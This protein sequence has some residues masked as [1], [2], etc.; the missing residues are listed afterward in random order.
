MIRKIEKI[1]FM[2]FRFLRDFKKPLV[3]DI[4]KKAR[5]H[6]PKLEEYYLL[7]EEKDMQTQKGGRKSFEFDENGIPVVPSYIDVEEKGFHYY[8][9]TIGQYGLSVYHTYLASGNEEDKRRF[10]NI[11][12]WFIEHKSEDE[13]GVFWLT[14]TKKPEY[15]I[16]G[17]W[18]SAFS[19]SRALSI[20]LRAYQLTE[21]K[22]YLECAQKAL[23]IYSVLNTNG[24]VQA[25]ESSCTAFEE[26]TAPFNIL[27]FDG[28][29]FSMLGLFDFQRVFPNNKDVEKLVD[30]GINGLIGLLPNYDMNFWIKYSLVSQSFYPKNEPATRGYYYLVLT[31]LRVFYLYTD[32]EEFFNYYTKIKKYD[33]W[34]NICRMYYAKF[35][36]LKKLNRL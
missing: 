4:Q 21:D 13:R 8:P 10:L 30:Q 9:I 12:N 29:F 20:L 18:V 33:T 28:C 19:Q 3:Y 17:P 24:G 11:A 5:M 34:F 27:V 36:A 23:K 22:S 2:F 16:E 26:Y 1:G 6:L 35:K 7:F 31:L 25:V 32:R 14:Y 15:R